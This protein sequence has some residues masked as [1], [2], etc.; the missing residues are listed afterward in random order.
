MTLRFISRSVEELPS[1]SSSLRIIVTS[2]HVQLIGCISCKIALDKI[3]CQGKQVRI[4]KTESKSYK[5]ST[6][7]MVVSID[8]SFIIIQLL[9]KK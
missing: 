3:D 5:L 1:F 8:F 2:H 6:R 7:R 9:V 4:K